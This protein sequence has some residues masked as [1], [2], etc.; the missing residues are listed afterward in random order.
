MNWL[1]VLK[2]NVLTAGLD[3]QFCIFVWIQTVLAVL[4]L[5]LLLQVSHIE[6]RSWQW[7][8]PEANSRNYQY[9]SALSVSW[10]TGEERAKI[11][12]LKENENYH[13]CVEM[14]IYMS[15]YLT[16]ETDLNCNSL[17][18]FPVC[19]FCLIKTFV[20]SQRHLKNVL[21]PAHFV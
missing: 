8:Q 6:L 2:N 19:T 5:D 9:S 4:N 11:Q 7:K 21:K 17:Y 10:A 12:A 13:L 15:R 1:L 14:R 16:P 20:R 18:F 3:V